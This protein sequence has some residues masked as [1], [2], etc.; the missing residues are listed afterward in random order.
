[1]TTDLRREYDEKGYVLVRNAIDPG[2]AGEMVDHIHWL[3]Q[4][5]PDV[6]PEQY[7]HHMLVGDPFMH[8]LVGD[9]RLLDIAEQFWGRISRSLPRTTLPKSH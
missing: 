5:Y 6:R 1:M 7:H 3:G 8:R 2:L 4:K 9:E